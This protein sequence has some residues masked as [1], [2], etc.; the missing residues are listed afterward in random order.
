MQPQ[1]NGKGAKMANRRDSVHLVYATETDASGVAVAL[2]RVAAAN[3]KPP[4]CRYEPVC[5]ADGKWV[6]SVVDT[7]D[8]QVLGY[9]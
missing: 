3:G 4:E 8:G 2:T 6:I 5:R 7:D 1:R 9:L